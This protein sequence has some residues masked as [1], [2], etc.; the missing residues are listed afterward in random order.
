MICLDTNVVIT[1]LNGRIPIIR[2]RLYAYFQ[3]RLPLGIPVIAHYELLYGCARSTKRAQ[4][5]AQLRA[6]LNQGIT[7]LPFE[8]GD[9][10]HAG[11]IRADLEKMGQPIGHYDFL[12][13]AQARS[14]GATLVTANTREFFRVPGLVVEDWSQEP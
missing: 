12:I 14:R 13:A 10:Q 7:V 6:F 9:A 4:S 11:D 3:K 8:I 5:E 1:A 2:E